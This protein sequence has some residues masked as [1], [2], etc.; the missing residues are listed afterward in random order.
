MSEPSVSHSML[1]AELGQYWDRYASSLQDGQ[2]TSKVTP[3]ELE[4]CVG[5]LEYVLKA[6]E[7]INLTRI[8]DPHEAAILHIYDSLVLL[9]Y[10]DSAPKGKLL[11]I[12]TGAGFPGLPLAITSNRP[13]VLMDSVGKKVK[14]VEACASQLGLER[15]ETVHERVESYALSHRGEFSVVVARAVAHL[16]TLVEYASPLLKKN[17]LLIVSKGVPA[18]DEVSD[19]TYAAQVCGFDAPMRYDL[20]LPGKRGARA[21]FV[22]KKSH[23]PSMKLP[24]A[25]GMAKKHPISK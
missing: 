19:G 23:K 17:G 8:I 24:R 13:S 11:D 6:N 2:L 5:H 21:I 20:S 4:L 16:S 3:D 22:F 18:A 1:V 25:V 10:V 9:P 7:S 12:G 14:V 15:V